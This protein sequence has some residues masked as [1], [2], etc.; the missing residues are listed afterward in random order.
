MVALLACMSF[1][2]CSQDELTEEG[3][4]LPVGQYPLA[5][6]LTHVRAHETGSNSV[7]RLLVV[8]KRSICP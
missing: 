2:S 5:V 6:S 3:R 8:N 7:C 1:A 4:P